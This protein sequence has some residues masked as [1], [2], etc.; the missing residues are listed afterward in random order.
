M[1]APG[2]LISLTIEK[3]AAG[4]RMIARVDGQ[5]V[6]VGGAIP[7]ERVTARVERVGKG[8]A[9]ADTTSV[10]VA[11]GDRRETIADP[12]C[13]GCLYAH[14]AYPRQLGLKALVIADAFGR[15]GH[16][17]LPAAVRV[18]G[19]P[20]EGTGCGRV[21]TC[22]TRVWASFAKGHTSSATREA[23]VSFCRRPPTCWIG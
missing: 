16:L 22:A 4:G 14:V 6:L 18:A 2:Q 23:H 21:F 7:G 3:P 13:G 17:E 15:I 20:E 10:E 11:S 12:L 9:Y 8:V 1:V 5:V 19:S